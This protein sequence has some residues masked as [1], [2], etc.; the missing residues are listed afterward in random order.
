MGIVFTAYV[1]VRVRQ[2]LTQR[3]GDLFWGHGGSVVWVAGKSK[4]IDIRPET[5]FFHSQSR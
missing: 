3:G 5:A 1:D 2:R 4:A